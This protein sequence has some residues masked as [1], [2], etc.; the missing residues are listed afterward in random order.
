MVLVRKPG[1]RRREPWRERWAQR[2]S[3]MHGVQRGAAARSRLGD[4]PRAT[5]H[6]AGHGPRLASR[7][8][9]AGDC[10]SHSVR[11]SGMPPSPLLSREERAEHYFSEWPAVAAHHVPEVASEI[12]LE[13]QSPRSRAS[14]G[15]RREEGEVADWA[16][17]GRC[18]LVREESHCD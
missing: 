2:A 3:D 11:V 6:L 12:Q 7:P 17:L 16:G 10:L 14:R 13:T 8:T 1:G 9:T 18:T 15:P 5:P 4:T